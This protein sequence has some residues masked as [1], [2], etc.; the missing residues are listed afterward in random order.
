MC[1]RFLTL[2]NDYKRKR[3]LVVCNAYPYSSNLYRNGFIHSRVK[4]YMKAGIDI[5][6]FW[7]HPPVEKAYQYEFDSVNVIVGNSDALRKHVTAH[8]YAVFLVHFPEP[9]RVQPLINA[10]PE[11][12]MIIWIHGFEAEAW[13]RRWFNVSLEPKEIENFLIKREG[14]YLPQNQFLRSLA[15]NDDIN[16]TFI[17]VSKWFKEIIVEPDIGVELDKS[18]VIH[19]FIDTETFRYRPKGVGMRKKILSLRPYASYK[20]ANDQ[21]VEAIR[22]LSRRPYFNDLEFTLA[23]AG[24]QFEEITAPVK[25]FKNVTLSNRFYESAEI[26]RLHEQHGI[27]LAP[28]RFDSQGVSMCEAMA[29][30]L[31]VV[32]SN[33][34]AIPEFV[35]HMETGMLAD[36]ESPL[37]LADQIE[38]LYFDV[39]L[40]SRISE[41]GS[42]SI[43]RQAGFS[44]TVER[45]IGLIQ[46]KVNYVL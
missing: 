24:P 31:V 19:N 36:A 14:Y 16:V 40:Y 3:A 17:N 23:G 44:E 20:Y 9:S 7:V 26:V 28:T 41:A 42:G 32:A 8:E 25:G 13:H 27:F 43:G 18:V 30:G 4:G 10:R 46:E 45:E 6:V 35:N 1:E 2:I 11:T 34:S 15:T 21:T 37:S 38:R 29:S 12:P 22:I 33:T 5:D 39:D